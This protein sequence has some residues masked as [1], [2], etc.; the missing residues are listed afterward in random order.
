MEEKIFWKIVKQRFL[1]QTFLKKGWL[2]FAHIRST[3]GTDLPETATRSDLMANFLKGY[4]GKKYGVHPTPSAVLPYASCD[5]LTQSTPIQSIIIHNLLIHFRLA[6]CGTTTWSWT[7]GRGQCGR[8]ACSRATTST[9]SR[10]SSSTTKRS[11]P[12]RTTTR[13]R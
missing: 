9:S 4:L 3:C 8:R 13:S 2:G 11:S 1:K 12:A 7:G 10:A 5:I 6:S